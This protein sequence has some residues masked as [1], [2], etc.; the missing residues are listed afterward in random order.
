MQHSKF[1]QIHIKIKYQQS[2]NVLRETYACR[3][4]SIPPPAPGAPPWA[5]PPDINWPI[6]CWTL[7]SDIIVVAMFIKAGL[8]SKLLISIPPSPPIIPGGNAAV[9]GINKMKF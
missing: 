4:P 7:G 9:A 2:K 6:I 5:T 3:S 1:A 8:L